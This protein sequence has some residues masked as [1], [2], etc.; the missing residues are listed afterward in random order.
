VCICIVLLPIIRM[1]QEH[2]PTHTHTER[3]REKKS[4][5]R[6][7]IGRHSF[8]SWP[9]FFSLGRRDLFRLDLLPGIFRTAT[10][11]PT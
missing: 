7:Y 10:L 3:E 4:I 11:F 6:S 5:E 9:F 2:R 1:Y 8:S